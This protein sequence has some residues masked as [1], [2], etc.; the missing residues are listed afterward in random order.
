MIQNASSDVFRLGF[1]VSFWFFEILSCSEHK[2]HFWISIVE[3]LNLQI[4]ERKGQ[5]GGEQGGGGGES[6]FLS[7]TSY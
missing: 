1:F 5:G 2:E 4:T 7:A 3:F 6:K